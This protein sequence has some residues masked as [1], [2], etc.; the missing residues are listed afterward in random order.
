M[1]EPS[2]PLIDLTAYRRGDV[3]GTQALAEAVDR[4]NRE[5]GFLIVAGHGP[6]GGV[7]PRPGPRP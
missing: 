1:R 7:R 5:I 4:A 3:A 6:H 2:V